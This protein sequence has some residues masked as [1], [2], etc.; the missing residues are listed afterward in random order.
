M[1]FLPFLA[2]ISIDLTGFTG[3]IED[4]IQMFFDYLPMMIMV[5]A[6]VLVV[7]FAFKGGFA[8]VRTLL[9][10]LLSGFSGR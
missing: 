6:P 2:A 9:S 8:F 7:A 3:A 4:L 1:E 10:D 5:A